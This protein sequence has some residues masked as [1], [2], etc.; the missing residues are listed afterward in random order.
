LG[1]LK[2]Q[3]QEIS[4]SN[5]PEYIRRLREAQAGRKPAAAEPAQPDTGATLQEQETV[6]WAR[7]VAAGQEIRSIRNLKGA[8]FAALVRL[9]GVTGT[10]LLSLEGFPD[11]ET[12]KER[13]KPGATVGEE[14]L[15]AYEVRGGR[16]VTITMEEG[17]VLLRMGAPRP[18][19]HPM[20]PEKMLRKAAAEAARRAKERP[21]ETDRDRRRR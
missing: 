10:K 3:W 2:G 13:V 19:A 1:Q 21:R 8:R 16:P 4:V 11:R 15:G 17:Q 5:E 7:E 6:R 14:V 20:S 9:Q 18:G 12:L